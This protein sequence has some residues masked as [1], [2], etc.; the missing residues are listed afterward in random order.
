MHKSF[1]LQPAPRMPNHRKI[2]SANST[3]LPLSAIGGDCF[4]TLIYRILQFSQFF[5]YFPR[6]WLSRLGPGVLSQTRRLLLNSLLGTRAQQ[7]AC[8]AICH[9]A[10]AVVTQSRT[11]KFSSPTSQQYLTTS[12]FYPSQGA[13]QWIHICLRWW[14]RFAFAGGMEDVE[15]LVLCPLFSF[16]TR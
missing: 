10:A 1:T 6:W 9:A 5:N 2:A 16:R 13:P 15:W 14:R 12:F 3:F 11:N 7:Y 8:L 4:S